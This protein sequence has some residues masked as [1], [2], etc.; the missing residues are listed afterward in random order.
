MEN[1]RTSNHGFHYKQEPISIHGNVD[2]LK[3]LIHKRFDE[4]IDA[5]PRNIKMAI[6]FVSLMIEYTY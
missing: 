2:V 4:L 1:I 6:W 5:E 3:Q